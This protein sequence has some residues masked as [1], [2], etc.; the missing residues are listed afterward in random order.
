MK[1]TGRTKDNTNDIEWHIWNSEVMNETPNHR[2]RNQYNAD[3]FV[4]SHQ[5]SQSSHSIMNSDE[6]QEEKTKE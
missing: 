2:I 1:A 3:V 4:T 6:K 5:K